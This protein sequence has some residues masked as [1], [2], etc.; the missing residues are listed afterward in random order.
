MNHLGR[1]GKAVS[2]ESKRPLYTSP[3]QPSSPD[4]KSVSPVK[5]LSLSFGGSDAD[6]L[7]KQK[8]EKKY[9]G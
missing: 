5:L 7:S 1:K 4:N 9:T 2:R 3:A 6:G 8:K